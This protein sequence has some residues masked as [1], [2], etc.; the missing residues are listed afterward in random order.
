MTEKKIVR[1]YSENSGPGSVREV[2]VMVGDES[3]PYVHKIELGENGELV[4]GVIMA[5]ITVAVKLGR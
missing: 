4:D 5:R 3:I 2:K 1:I